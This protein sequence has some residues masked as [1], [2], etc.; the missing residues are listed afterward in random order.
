M[1]DL[2]SQNEADSEAFRRGVILRSTGSWY[3]VS[4]L[5]TLEVY[6]CRA[7]G[8]LRLKGERD[9]SSAFG[10]SSRYSSRY[11]SRLHAA[12]PVGWHAAVER[13]ALADI[14]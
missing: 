10:V 7:G 6:G 5:G 13:P 3:Q 11:S 4:E 1:T 14:I 9:S 2:G 12:R 8:R